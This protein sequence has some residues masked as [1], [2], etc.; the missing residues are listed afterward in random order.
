M[1]LN[2]EN[3]SAR[4]REEKAIQAQ[5]EIFDLIIIGGGITGAG[6]ALDCASRG[7]KTLLLEKGDYA[8]GTSSKSTK[9]IHGGLRYLKQFRMGEVRRIGRERRV[10]L[11]NAPHLIFPRPML[12]PLYKG[13]SFSPFAAN[14]GLALYDFLAGVGKGEKRIML[15]RAKAM[16]AEPMLAKINLL[17]AGLYYEYHTFDWALTLAVLKTA[18]SFGAKCFNYFGVRKINAPENGIFTVFARDE[19]SGKT[20]E[21]RSHTLVNATGPWADQLTRLD[22]RKSGRILRHTKGVHL[23]VAFEKLPVKNPVYFDAPGNRMVFVIPS[24]TKNLTFI[25]T[26]DTDYTGNLDHPEVSKEDVK[27]LCNAVTG[28]FPSIG[29]L[30]KDV[31]SSWAG[32]RPLIQ[33]PGRSPSEISRKDEVLISSNGMISI[34]GGKL[35]GYRY[36]A[37]KV[38]NLVNWELERKKILP[39]RKSATTNIPLQKSAFSPASLNLTKV[40]WSNLVNTMLDEEGAMFPMD[41]LARRIGLLY[42]DKNNG[43]DCIQHLIPEMEKQ[44]GWT[45]NYTEQI[46]K[47]TIHEISATRNFS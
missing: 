41:I 39:F 35:T 19:I 33:E 7:I 45:P 11:Q 23:A 14:I 44:L 8:S 13:G 16:E 24:L 9:L 17:G 15:T 31:V 29:L 18:A 43:S 36:M 21:L 6:I 2:P 38:G 47:Q 30:E 32:V 42:F 12:L 25:G 1:R 5:Q 4:N 27:Y 22:D 46:I 28:V 40:N 3:L 26:T 37:E 10:L 20:M 34:A